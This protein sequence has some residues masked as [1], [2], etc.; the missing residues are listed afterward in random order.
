MTHA[1]LL[2]LL[3]L[4][5]TTILSTSVVEVDRGRRTLT[6]AETD[7]GGPRRLGVAPAAAAALARLRPGTAVVLTMS[8]S[9]VVGIQLAGRPAPAPTS[10]V[11]QLPP[12]SNAPQARPIPQIAPGAPATP[13]PGV[14]PVAVAPTRPAVSPVAVRS[15]RSPGTPKPVVLP[16]DPPPT[17]VPSPAP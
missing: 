10:N 3:A 4:A 12:G 17:P 2:L 7:A 5:Q 6:V 13:S 9:T 16:S 8:G 14:S 15:P 1:I 11:P